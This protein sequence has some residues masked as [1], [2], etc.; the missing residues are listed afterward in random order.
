MPKR[1]VSARAAF[2]LVELLVVIGIIALLISVL[3]PSLNKARAQA[4]RI[5]CLTNMRTLGQYMTMYLNDNKGA[6]PRPAVNPLP[7][8]WIYWQNTS[9]NRLLKDGQ[10]AKIAKGFKAELYRCPTVELNEYR[11]GYPYSY[12]LNEKISGY[13]GANHPCLRISQIRRPAQKLLMIDESID[14]VDDGCWAWQESAGSGRNVMSN[15]HEQKRE[16][17]TDPHYGRGNVMFADGHA[18]FISRRNSFDP[19]FYDPKF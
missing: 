6:Y 8:D 3:L 16:S 9:P 5:Q 1:L 15:R 17:V 14:T 7:E 18:D 11:W 19:Q 4:K 2:T 13:Q 12:S 10:L